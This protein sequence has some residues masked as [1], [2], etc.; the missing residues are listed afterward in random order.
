MGAHVRVY[1]ISCAT[2][3]EEPSGH[4]PRCDLNAFGRHA[5]MTVE[6]EVELM[7]PGRILI[8][9]NRYSDN[10]INKGRKLVY[11]QPMHNTLTTLSRTGSG[12]RLYDWTPNPKSD[13]KCKQ[14]MSSLLR[15]H[16]ILW[17]EIKKS[18]GDPSNCQTIVD[19]SG[20][21]Q[22]KCQHESISHLELIRK[23]SMT[24]GTG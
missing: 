16:S 18:A 21:H 2:I 19:A 11:W 14:L 3:Q 23:V 8:K 12:V 4:V 9:S 22:S 24:H 17:E 7:I 20:S 15:Y 1:A 6:V 13:I 5:M 10:L